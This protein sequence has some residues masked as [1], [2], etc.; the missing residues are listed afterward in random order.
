[1]NNMKKFISIAKYFILVAI[2][3][4]I[5]KYSEGIIGG[6]KGIT[7]AGMP[8]VLGLCIAYIL[9]IL[10]IKLEK[11]YFPNSKNQ[12]VI[13]TR[14]AACIF[15][16]IILIIGIMVILSLIVIPQLIKA[17]S[18]I[19]EG[20]PRIIGSIENFI[21]TNSDKYEIVGKAL[22]TLKIDLEGLLH[23]AMSAVTSV[24][25]GLMN[26]TF[27][28]VGSLT[29]GLMN[30]IIAL[31]FAIYV[32]ANKEGL[33]LNIRKVMKA[34]L[35]DKSIEKINYVMHIVNSAFSSFISGQF[36]EAVIIGCLCTI[37]MWIFRFPYAATVGAFISATALIPVV[38]AYL[39]AALGAFMILTVSP[40]KALLFLV[41]ISI[42]QQLENNLIY[43]RVVGSSI[44]LP[45]IWVFA[46]ITIGGGLG[47]IVGMLLS[48]PIA[49]SIYKLFVNKVNER[50]VTDE[51]EQDET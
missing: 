44:G 24:F 48:V 41:F 45:G 9:N 38:G 35:K 43:P 6:I 32:L 31:T 34:F 26:S 51:I 19:I 23:N 36:I 3:V 27:A 46:A 13:R 15:L 2:L 16:S 22:D 18:V 4:L 1:M 10:M 50:L 47:G 28:F 33:E 40:I 5:V 21:E 20:V 14:R 49:A 39:G 29:S 7:K 12:F 42:L 30:F 25:R 11:V 37:G 8:L 17:A